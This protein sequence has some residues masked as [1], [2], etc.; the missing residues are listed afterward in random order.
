MKRLA[1]DRLPL[2]ARWPRLSPHLLGRLPR[3]IP[4]QGLC[5][6]LD[7]LFE[8]ARTSGELDFIEGRRLEIEVTDANL[9]LHLRFTDRSFSPANPIDAPD[10][11]IRGRLDAFLDLASGREDADALFFNRRLHIQGDAETI[12]HTKHFLDAFEAPP[13]LQRLLVR[14]ASG[15]EAES[16]K[17]EE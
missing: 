8:P 7:R 12:M 14:L 10:I 13:W 11:R 1:M 2:P 5:F 6:L 4:E 17:P 16:R 9:R 15:A 3:P